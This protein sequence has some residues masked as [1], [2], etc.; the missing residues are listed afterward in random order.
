MSMFVQVLGE[1][2]CEERLNLT[3]RI[4]FKGYLPRILCVVD[5]YDW[6]ID[7][8]STD[9]RGGYWRV[10][11]PAEY[12]LYLQRHHYG[13]KYSPGG[14]MASP[15]TCMGDSG[16]PL[17]IKT[18]PGRYVL[19]GKFDGFHYDFLLSGSHIESF[20]WP[21][22]DEVVQGI[23]SGGRVMGDCGGINNPVHYTR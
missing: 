16:G 13:A 7:I 9:G 10:E 12:N 14:Y 20:C 23:V 19:T 8:W 22:S 6:N 21:R 17:Y 5:R 2:D 3:L 4:N 11:D 1:R 18:G 15:G